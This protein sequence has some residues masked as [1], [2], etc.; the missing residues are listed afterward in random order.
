MGVNMK[1]IQ[2]MQRRLEAMQ[3]ELA[4][5]IVE[6][7]A[8]GGVVRAQVTGAREFRGISIDPSAVDPEDVE[9]LEDL[10]TVAIQ[11]AMSRANAMAEE[12]M[13]ALTGGM[14]IPGLM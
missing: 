10:I 3:T 7:S 13:G 2:Q 6:G 5:T 9:V 12:K 8:G 1:A 4:E 11:D 14:K